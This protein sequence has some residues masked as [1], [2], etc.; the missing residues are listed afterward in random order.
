MMPEWPKE[1]VATEDHSPSMAKEV[2]LI[3]YGQ[4]G[5]SLLIYELTGRIISVVSILWEVY[6]KSTD[7][8]LPPIVF[9]LIVYAT[10]WMAGTAFLHQRRQS[11]AK[12]IAESAYSQD[13]EWG[14]LYI[15]T[16]HNRY[17][18]RR[19]LLRAFLM[20]AEPISWVAVSVAVWAWR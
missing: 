6:L 15:K 4:L 9:L 5:R 10:F 18:G 17:E 12:L 7:A 13:H 3:E 16:Y 14:T 19:N 1:Y 8:S 11:M 20:G 2:L